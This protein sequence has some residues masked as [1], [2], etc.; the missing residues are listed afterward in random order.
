MLPRRLP[1]ACDAVAAIADMIGEP[2]EVP[3][4]EVQLPPENTMKP[5]LGS[6]I[7]ERSGTMR[8]PVVVEI[9]GPTCHDG[10]F[11][12]LE[13]PPPELPPLAPL[14]HTVSLRVDGGAVDASES[15]V[16]APTPRATRALTT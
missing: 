12:T 8:G 11:H 7:T 2:I 15:T 6:P 4:I 13:Y 5:V 3:P 16:S 1:Q 10:W 14:F 9:P